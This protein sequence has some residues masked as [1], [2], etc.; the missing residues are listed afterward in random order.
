MR[1]TK[2]YVALAVMVLTPVTVFPQATMDADR[3]AR[4]PARMSQF[5]EEGR[6]SGAV[7]LLA[8]DGDVILHEA[9]GYREL[10]TRDPIHTDTIFQVQ[11][12]TKPV[13][14]VA[15]MILIE[16]GRLRLDDSPCAV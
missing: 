3:L 16:E 6:I 14:A 11:S 4:I 5:V 9:V 2:L 10:E 12:M 1:L 15:A 7:M 8:R 13:T